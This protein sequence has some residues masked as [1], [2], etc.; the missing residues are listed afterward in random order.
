MGLVGDSNNQASIEMCGYTHAFIDFKL[1]SGGESNTDR[2]ARVE[3]GGGKL[4]FET[5]GGYDRM[6]IDAVGNVGIGISS[7]IVPL[8]IA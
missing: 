5:G 2:D 1:E 7:P 3:Y 8:H 4:K 6:T